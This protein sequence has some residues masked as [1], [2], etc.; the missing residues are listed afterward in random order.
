[1]RQGTQS[2]NIEEEVTRRIAANIAKAAGVG[3][4]AAVLSSDAPRSV[5]NSSPREVIGIKTPTGG[6]RGN[7]GVRASAER[8]RERPALVLLSPHLKLPELLRTGPLI[9][10][11]KPR[12]F[13]R[14]GA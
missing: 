2:T 7:G 8:W 1:M 4:A 6:D 14:T 13:G 5:L 11:E 10:N 9:A 12:R 3:E